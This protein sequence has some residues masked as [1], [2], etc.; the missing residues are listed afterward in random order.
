[1]SQKHVEILTVVLKNLKDQK[2]SPYICDQVQASYIYLGISLQ[3]IKKEIEQIQTWIRESINDL[4]SYEYWLREKHNDFYM[5]IT[6]YNHDKSHYEKKWSFVEGRIQWVEWM[7]VNH[8]IF[9]DVEVDD[10]E[11]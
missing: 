8:T 1:M 7:I 5:N 3:Y 4:F 9:D 6:T 10:M 11:V 2:N